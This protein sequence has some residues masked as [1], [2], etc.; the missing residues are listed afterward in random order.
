[1]RPPVLDAVTDEDIGEFLR[2]T[3]FDELVPACR[4]SGA[5]EFAADVLERFSNPYIRH[6]L[7]GIM[8][9]ATA[10]IRARVVP[11]VVD[12]ERREGR[13]PELTSF[14]FASFLLFQRGDSLESRRA[15]EQIIPADDGAELIRDLWR[16]TDASASGGIAQFVDRVCSEQSLW[17]HD[18]RTLPGFSE[19]ITIHLSKMLQHGVRS[20]LTQ[21]L[22]RSAAGVI[23]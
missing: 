7:I 6:A 20:A 14:G 5:S 10:K 11:T 4:V 12:Y 23:Q 19:A 15:A 3:M 17:G 8:L 22:A 21:L 13:T 2:R 18:L 16:A 1:M 9:Q